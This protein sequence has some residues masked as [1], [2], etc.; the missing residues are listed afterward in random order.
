MMLQRL[1][2]A[3]VWLAR[4]SSG[5]NRFRFVLETKQCAK[6]RILAAGDPASTIFWSKCLVFTKTAGRSVRKCLGTPAC[7]EHMA[8]F[9]LFPGM[10]TLSLGSDNDHPRK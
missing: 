4:P 6:T 1:S 3:V 5:R 10:E 8:Q 9:R 2:L 7:M